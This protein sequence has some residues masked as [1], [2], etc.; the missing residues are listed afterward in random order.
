M[1][2]AGFVV[3]L[4][5]GLRI[6]VMITRPSKRQRTP[7]ARRGWGRPLAQP[8]DALCPP[9]RQFLFSELILEKPWQT[10]SMLTIA[11]YSGRENCPSKSDPL[12]ESH[13]TQRKAG[14]CTLTRKTAE[15]RRQEPGRTRGGG[16][17][18]RA[19]PPSGP[20]HA[21]RQS[22]SERGA[23][24]PPWPRLCERAE[25]PRRAPLPGL[26]RR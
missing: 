17:R 10:R 23:T 26:P 3:L 2:L 21:A 1:G 24:T 25:G 12:Q 9:P 15:T 16:V 19:P 20:A 22:G 4:P 14:L 8:P 7:T 18:S 6:K 5:R 13:G 11:S